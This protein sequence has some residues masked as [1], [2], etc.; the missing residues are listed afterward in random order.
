MNGEEEIEITRE[1]VIEQIRK[2]KKEKTPAQN[3]K[4]EAWR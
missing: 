2:L 1:K 3:G 4:K